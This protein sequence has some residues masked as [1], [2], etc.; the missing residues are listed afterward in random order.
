MNLFPTRPIR[1]MDFYYQKLK[2]FQRAGIPEPT[3]KKLAMKT[4]RAVFKRHSQPRGLQLC[5]HFQGD[6]SGQKYL[7]KEQE[8]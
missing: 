2:E 6:F 7:F 1:Q 5:W 3:A 8:R 4:G